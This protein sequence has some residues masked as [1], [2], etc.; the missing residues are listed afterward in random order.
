[1]NNYKMV[2]ILNA[3]NA[4]EE[5]RKKKLPV[6]LVYPMYKNLE[7]LEYAG[8]AYTRSLQYI[9]ETFKNAE[10]KETE[11]QKLINEE[12][13]AK[14]EVISRSIIEELDES[15]YD[16]LSFEDIK[17]LDFMIS[18]EVRETIESGDE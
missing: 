14:I 18:D 7:S 3:F 1:M 12:A 4:N 2:Q 9:E 6:S 8:Q 13:S 11:I 16:A 17:I 10:D 15:K 5:L